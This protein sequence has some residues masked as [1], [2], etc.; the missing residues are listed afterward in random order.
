MEGE[1]VG[2]GVDADDANEVVLLPRGIFSTVRWHPSQRPEIFLG[3]LSSSLVL[4]RL[5][6]GVLRY[7]VKIS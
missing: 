2:G 5:E 1:G 6:K 4:T 7:N 3:R